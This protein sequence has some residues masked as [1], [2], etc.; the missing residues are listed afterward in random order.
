M[1][2]VSVLFVLVAIMGLLLSACAEGPSPASTQ[3]SVV[4]ATIET[5]TIEKSMAVGFMF[6]AASLVLAAVLGMF[7]NENF[8]VAKKAWATALATFAILISFTLLY[9]SFTRVDAQKAGVVLR[10]GEIIGT[11]HPGI[12]W[13]MP[14]VDSVVLF[15]RGDWTYATMTD[16][17]N[18][19]DEDFRD[20]VVE[21]RTSDGV[22]AQVKFSVQGR[23]LPQ[24]APKLYE[25]YGS[26]ENAIRQLV[27]NSLRQLVPQEL[28]GLTADQLRGDTVAIEAAVTEKLQAK[29]AEGG[30]ELI[31]FGFRKPA[32]GLDAN[33]NGTGDY[34]E[35]LDAQ[36][37][38]E[39][40][41]Q[42]A[43][44][45]VKVVQQQSLQQAQAAE[46]QKA[47]DIL[48]AEARAAATMA[49]QK[50]IA[51]AQLYAE[52]QKAEAAK[53]AADA[54]AYVT[55]TEASAQAEANQQL[56]ASL[57]PQLIQFFMWQ[58]WDG[59]LPVW[60]TGDGSQIFALP[61]ASPTPQ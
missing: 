8:K 38:A 9:G 18:Q 28:S 27:K 56:A 55:R 39:L 30:L 26:L 14:Y 31:S 4:K 13:V 6:V 11:T 40:A 50:A 22:V 45:Q 5:I 46:G 54:A 52:R 7:I 24:E 17:K 49:E 21:V 19:G 35:Q 44:M 61:T 41:A 33:G 42:T 48:A 47:A 51:D 60:M 20:Y 2:K 23:I 16:P 36:R 12:N 37:V 32:L 1:K 58:K 59:Q 10:Q 25:S 29:M 34:D 43:E 57:T 15:P 3:G 53:V